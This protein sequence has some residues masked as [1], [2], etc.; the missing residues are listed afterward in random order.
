MISDDCSSFFFA[1]PA[2]A[3]QVGEGDPGAL[4]VSYLTGLVQKSFAFFMSLALTTD[5]HAASCG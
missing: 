2:V 3:L 4:D 5:R 1:F